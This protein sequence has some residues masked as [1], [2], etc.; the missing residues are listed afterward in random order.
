MSENQHLKF[1]NSSYI[2]VQKCQKT[3]ALISQ[4]KI[5]S[6]YISVQKCQKTNVLISQN[7]ILH[8]HLYK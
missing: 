5:L 2:S 1:N 7:K 6:S 3:N 4:N 8:Q